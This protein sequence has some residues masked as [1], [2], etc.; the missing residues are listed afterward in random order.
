MICPNCQNKRS[1]KD[2]YNSDMCY[3]CVYKEKMATQ[4]KSKCK[5]CNKEIPIGRWSYCSD[6]C[7]EKENKTRIDNYWT[8]N[9]RL[10]RANFK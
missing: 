5:I 3:Q 6:N 2:F 7:A 4:P 10:P 1:R 9:I 8:K